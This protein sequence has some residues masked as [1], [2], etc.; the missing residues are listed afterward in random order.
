MAD[1]EKR[2]FPGMIGSIDCMHWQWKNCPVALKGQY[3]GKE[4]KPTIVLEAIAS[5]DTRIWHAFFGMH[6]SLNDINVLDRSPLLCTA[7]NGSILNGT[8][9]LRGKR[10]TKRY[11]LADGIYPDWPIFVK[12]ISNPSTAKEK[13][14]AKMQQSVRKDVER[15]FGV[16]QQCWHIIKTPCRIWD[17][18]TIA[19]IMRTCII[20]H[21]MRIEHRDIDEHCITAMESTQMPS[22]SGVE[23]SIVGTFAEYCSIRPELKDASSYMELRKDLIDLSRPT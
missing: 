16:L 6:G 22:A 7:I 23:S 11:L 5:H 10:R 12:T 19:S 18:D 1:N 20:L 13:L 3:Q 9:E 21:N 17:E 2:G 4:G 14:F 15:A 8:Y